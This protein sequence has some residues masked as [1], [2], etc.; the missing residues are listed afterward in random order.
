[1]KNELLHTVS[2]DRNIVRTMK[3]RKKLDWSHLA[4]ELPSKTGYLRK[5]RSKGKTRK[6]TSARIE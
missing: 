2:E 4:K 5:N 1:M 3:R 6:K